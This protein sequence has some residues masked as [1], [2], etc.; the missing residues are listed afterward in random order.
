MQQMD[1]PKLDNEQHEEAR[2]KVRRIDRSRFKIAET[3][4][5]PVIFVAMVAIFAIV[6][7]GTYLTIG[8]IGSV[9]G[10]NTV[11]LVIMVSAMVPLLVGE[12]DLSVASVSGLSAMILAVLNTH[13]HVPV[14]EAAFISLVVAVFVG[15][16]NA[17]LVV[18]VGC[19]S[20]IATLATGTVVTGVVF[21]ISGSQ[22]ISGTSQT[23]SKWIY[24]DTFFGVP[25]EFYYG[26]VIIIIAWYVLE[27]TPLGQRVA[28]VGQSRSVAK[29]SGVHVQRVR[30]GSF[31]LAGLIAGISGIVAVGTSGSADPSSGP[32]FLLP[33]LA[34]VFLGET[35]IRPGRLNI[36]GATLAAY[37]LAA[38]VDGLELMGVQNYIQNLFYG[39]ALVVAIMV[40]QI[41]KR[42]Q[43]K[44]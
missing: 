37:F 42:Y 2:G 30:I 16:F 28:F 25:L 31:I 44:G 14:V 1:K 22:I 21:A 15:I 17:L 36:F 7:P 13:L 5:L 26:L 43:L 23:L 6:E 35:T 40:S 4:S 34:A 19:N 39:G 3:I 24:G 8:N 11:L 33:A 9:L 38:G 27:M 20:F 10:T 12:F 41:I 29:L 32:A 18:T